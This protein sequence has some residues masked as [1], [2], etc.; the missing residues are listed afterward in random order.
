M[1]LISQSGQEIILLARSVKFR[2]M[3][4]IYALVLGFAWM[5]Y[6]R[7]YL[8]MDGVSYLDLGELWWSRDWKNAVNGLWSPLYPILLGLWMK[9]A[10]D[11]VQT[12]LIFAHLLNF[13]FYIF[14]MICFEFLLFETEANLK[15]AKQQSAEIF[16]LPEWVMRLLGYVLFIWTACR[17]NGLARL[18][19][20]L[21]VSSVFYLSTA[22][23]LRIRR[24][25]SSPQTM[26]CLGLSLGVGYLAKTP[27]LVLSALTLSGCFWLIRPLK[28]AV[29]RVSLSAVTM[30][31]LISPFVILLSLALGKLS[32]GESANLNYL[33][34]INGLPDRHWRGE[35]PAY[36]QPLHP[37]RKLLTQPELSEYAEPITGTY[38]LWLNPLYWYAGVKPQF[39]PQ[40]MLQN[41][42]K[43]LPGFGKLFV[44]STTIFLPLCFVG[45]LLLSRRRWAG[46]PDI[47]TNWWWL[48]PSIIGMLMFV[49]VHVEY[50]YLIGFFTV[51]W[52]A[53]FAS[54]R[55]AL[56]ARLSLL[57]ALTLLCCI[58]LTLET[59]LPLLRPAPFS[60]LSSGSAI[61]AA[62]TLHRLGIRK[63]DRV[64]VAGD[65]YFTHSYRW[66]R[67]AG[68]RIIAENPYHN[69]LHFYDADAPSQQ[70]MVELSQQLGAVAIIAEIKSAALVKSGWQ[71]CGNTSYYL[72]D[73]RSP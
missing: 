53:L 12:Y 40:R 33:W 21:M 69:F 5:W 38:P 23:M 34:H 29:A 18:A 68:V 20:D 26:I 62:E 17:L 9:L 73:L 41:T 55:A 43:N 56:A 58:P 32:F 39:A 14:S 70:K 6:E 63:G 64:V 37:P 49:P 22:L 45:S 27:L 24:G 51:F 28:T 8:S 30:L 71:R 10:P 2:W 50:R 42:W 31:L 54:I 25:L 61:E 19:P 3:L 35:N 48:L 66:A 46:M 16:A 59:I 1:L 72:L 11:S 44:S 4:R 65:V 7:N 36:G 15:Q 13:V 67:L 52:L 57:I 47:L 60:E